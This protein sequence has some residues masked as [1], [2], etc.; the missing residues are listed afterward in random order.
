MSIA[1]TPEPNHAIP[2]AAVFV[3]LG[4]L[5][6]EHQG[7]VDGMSSTDGDVTGTDA[8]DG[9]G[10]LTGD[11][12][13]DLTGD[14][15]G[16]MTGDGDGDMTGDGDGDGDGLLPCTLTISPGDAFVEA[17][18][19]LDDGEVLCLADGVYAQAMD[20]PSNKHVRAVNVGR[21]ELDGGGVLGVEWSGG[22]FQMLGENSSAAGLKVHHAGQYS[23]A[24]TVAGSNNTLTFMS[25]SHGGSHKHKIPLKVSGSGHLIEDS[26][27]FGEGRYVVQCFEGEGITLR[28]NIVRWDST[29]AGEPS[30]PN[31]AMSNYACS[32][33]IWENNISLDYG[34]PETEMVHCGDVCMSTTFEES[35]NDVQY[36]GMMVVNH[37]PD[38]SNN[39]AFRADSKT[40]GDLPSLGVSVRDLYVRDVGVAVIVQSDYTDFTLDR[41]TLVNVANGAGSG[42]GGVEFTCAG[43][44][45]LEH[46][47]VD[48]VETDQ[49][50]FPFPAEALAKAD[51]CAPAER[52]SAW[53][54]FGG[55]LQEYVFGG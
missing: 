17:F 11:G 27:F 7:G 10:D 44:A 43:D 18:A 38:T 25:C 1:T 40:A 31:A 39:R 41:C 32:A 47:Y 46:R 36:R 14:G 34:V 42:P 37:S 53:C 13:G 9:D 12:D 33:M 3:L 23:D 22:V 26:W 8:G 24:C 30:E 35:N 49:P 29:I 2:R 28:R 4:V 54:E 51:M 52:Q 19:Q 5:G 48:G 55:T 6:C 45:E 20:V 16:D 50:L 21:A 15:D